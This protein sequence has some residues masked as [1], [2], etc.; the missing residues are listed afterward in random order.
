[1]TVFPVQ[2]NGP[3][4]VWS[5]IQG[6]TRYWVTNAAV[7]LGVFGALQSGALSAAELALALPAAPAQLEVLLDSLVAA[8]LLD[9]SGIAYSLTEVSGEF[10]V[11]GRE[12]YMGELV[13]HSPG[14][15]D[16]WPL[17]AETV[18]GGRP[19]YPVD[20]D[21]RFWR[22]ISA[23]AFTTQLAIARRTVQL[24]GLCADGAAPRV[25]DLGAG[26]APWAVALLQA[27]PGATAIA[28][29]LPGVADLARDSAR[30][31]GVADRLTVQEGDFQLTTFAPAS[32]DV[33]V[34]ANVVRTEGE[35]CA[36]RLLLR[37]A[38]WLKP[39]GTMLIADYFLD[40]ERRA[41]STA[42]LLGATMMANTRRGRTFT[43]NRHRAWLHDAGFGSVEV[44]EPLPGAQVLV[45]RRVPALDPDS[46]SSAVQHG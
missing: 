25:L 33:V 41:A 13:L 19:P 8:G 24:A 11:P 40:E 7:R 18:Q 32:F 45:A 2:A 34:L 23:A 44:V 39:G 9:R 31:H 21:V 26:A 6:H 46:A 38:G 10:L 43:V 30:L 35:E 1:V 14:R 16:N 20:E 27:L 5:I 15:H 3:A 12:R 17:L 36:P 29:D 37:A 28:N 22:D 4:A 42:L